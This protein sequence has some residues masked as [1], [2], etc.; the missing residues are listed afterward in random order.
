MCKGPED[1]EDV[2]VQGREQRPGH[3]EQVRGDSRCRG[4]TALST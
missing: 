4:K 2:G 1:I 3:M